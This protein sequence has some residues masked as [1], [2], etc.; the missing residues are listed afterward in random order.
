MSNRLDQL[1]KDK[2]ADHTL[3]PPASAWDRVRAGLSKKNDTPLVLR[4][5]AAFLVV[6]VLTGTLMWLAS[7]ERQSNSPTLSTRAEPKTKD[8]APLP[9]K[10][11]KKGVVKHQNKHKKAKST[12]PAIHNEQ[13][14]EIS[15]ELHTAVATLT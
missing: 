10:V 8:Q 4:L 9:I 1:F 2:L 6:S 11:E 13:K 5:A 7:R 12:S 15:P 3:A 14:Q